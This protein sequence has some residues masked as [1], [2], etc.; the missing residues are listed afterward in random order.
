MPYPP[1][2]RYTPRHA[3]PNGDKAAVADWMAK[4]IDSVELTTAQL[5][6]RSMARDDGRLQPR[7]PAPPEQHVGHQ[8]DDGEQASGLLEQRHSRQARLELS[9]LAS[10]E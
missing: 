5:P 7:A 4:V 8:L 2:R 1:Y 3:V 6:Q 9:R 10:D